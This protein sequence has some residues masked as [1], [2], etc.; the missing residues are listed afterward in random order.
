M[1]DRLSLAISL[2]H[3]AGDGGHLAAARDFSRGVRVPIVATN[4]VHYHDPGRR[5]LQDVLTCVRHGCTIQEAG[6]RL[7][8]NAERYLKSP[9]QMRRAFA[10]C[11]EAIARGLQIAAACTFSLAELRYNYPIEAVPAGKIPSLHLRELTYEGAIERYPRGTPAAVTA[12]IEKELTFIC[13]SKYESYFLTVHDLVRYARSRGILCQGRG[14]AANSAVCYCLG[15]TSVDPDKFQ[16]VFERFASDARNEP[17]DI[18][19]DFEHERRE[20]VIQYVYEKYGRSHAG[21]TASLITY[22]GRSAI[23]DVGKALGLGEDL[24]DQLA[25]KL[26]WWHK[27][28]LEARQLEEA[29]VDGSD[30]TIRQL[31]GLS[32]E[33]LGFPRHL[34]QHVGGMVISREPLWRHRPDRKRLDGRSHRHRMGQGRSRCARAVQGRHPRAGGC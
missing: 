29:G 22:R 1:R 6:H 8:P 12:L 21:M 9:E 19:I 2:T 13:G 11:P 5:P 32:G 3:D 14:S 15:V 17:P 26:D 25:D 31:L 18:D 33:V 27:G 7:F 23:R 34:S 28:T 16:L 20:E 4:H 30:V 10:G 24:I